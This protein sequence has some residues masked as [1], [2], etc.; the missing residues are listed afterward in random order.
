VIK[1]EGIALKGMVGREREST[2][3]RRKD[4]FVFLPETQTSLL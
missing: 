2:P 4:V 1:H 3:V